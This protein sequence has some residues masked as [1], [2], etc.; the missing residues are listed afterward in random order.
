VLVLLSLG[1]SLSNLREASKALF[2]NRTW[3]FSRTPKYADLQD[4]NDWKKKKYQLPVDIIWIMELILVMLGLWAIGTAIRQTSYPVLLILV[5]FTISY[6]FVM[7]L[8]ILQSRKA[9]A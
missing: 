9:N 7:L 5:P 6:G 2:T 3:E 4:K 1:I 8:S